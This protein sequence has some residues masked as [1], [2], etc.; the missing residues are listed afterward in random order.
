MRRDGSTEKQAGFTMIEAVVAL[1]VVAIVLAAI[2]SLYAGNTRGASQLEQRV[3]LVETARLIATAVTGRND[4]GSGYLAGEI[5]GHAWQM[6]MTPF[7][8]GGPVLPESEWVPH[9][10]VLRV[11]SPAGGELSVETVRL[12]RKGGR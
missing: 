8:G 6:Q 3:A 7:F 12:R 5:N 4:L 1:A 11:Q 9:L 10:V 2:G